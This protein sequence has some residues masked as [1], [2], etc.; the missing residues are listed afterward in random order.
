MFLS[1]IKV[2][3][4]KSG[5]FEYAQSMS[6]W[7]TGS[8]Y[9][10]NFISYLL[11]LPDSF[12]RGLCINLEGSSIFLPLTLSMHIDILGLLVTCREL[13]LY[14]YPWLKVAVLVLQPSAGKLGSATL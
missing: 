3:K 5:Q 7:P 2:S 11:Y 8:A 14:A 10:G 1:N 9:V 12:P 4:C 6:K 13:Y